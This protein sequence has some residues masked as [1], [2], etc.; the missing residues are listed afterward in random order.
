MRNAEI[1]VNLLIPELLLLKS[2]GSLERR[3]IFVNIGVHVN[4]IF[5]A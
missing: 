3:S 4:Y 1:R 2:Q 5:I